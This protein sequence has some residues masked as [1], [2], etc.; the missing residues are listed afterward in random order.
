MKQD[1]INEIEKLRR[2]KNAIILAHTYQTTDIIAIADFMGDSLQLSIEA[3]RVTADF[4]VFCGVRF[5]AETAAMLNPRAK[6]L[7]PALDAGCPMA[8]MV[9]ADQ[10]KEF[11]HKHPDAAVVCYVNSSAEV[12]AESD[13]CCTSSNAVKVLA[14]LPKDQPVLFV[15]DQNLGTWAA[16]QAGREII[17]WDGF[18]PIHHWGFE[19]AQVKA[20]RKK[21]PDH[22]LLAHPECDEG[23]VE[24]A[25]AVM[26]TSGMINEA[27]RHD[28]LII[29]TE[30]GLTDYLT[31]KYPQ[32]SIIP[33]NPKAICKN[34][35]KTT[36]PHV[37]DALRFEQHLVT[38]EPQVAKRAVKS[39]ERML[40]L[41]N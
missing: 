8:D 20:L 41:S 33:L 1:I 38:V 3:S 12:K 39:L 9:T 26:S 36:L 7:L 5:M 30:K 31:E 32:K 16:R 25:D 4:I 18:C 29:A 35:K 27:T 6:V 40:E 28:K 10:I 15:P 37:L 19:I 22:R 21:Y 11:R 2:E 14:S 24:C 23:I 34:M 13:I 17:P